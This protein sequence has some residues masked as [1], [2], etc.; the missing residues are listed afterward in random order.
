MKWKLGRTR[1][2]NVTSTLAL[3]VALGGTSYAAVSFPSN[4]IG[5]SQLQA[6]AVTSGKV[7][8]GSLLSRDFKSGQLPKGA[9]GAKGATGGTGASGATGAAGVAGAKGD[10]GDAGSAVAFGKV[11][12]DGTIDLT[13][14][15][16]IVQA[17]VTRPSTGHYCFSGVTFTPLN[18]VAN[19]LISNGG[20]APGPDIYTEIGPQFGC[21]VGTQF[22]IDTLVNNAF[23]D[24]GFSFA[25]N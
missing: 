1:Y 5:T 9:T 7:K 18:V 13:K 3:I 24:R 12:S 4:S 25:V 20:A 6:N 22:Q 17:N 10:M 2:A 15:K 8:N 21:P 11:A 14:S 16:S 23:S 19:V